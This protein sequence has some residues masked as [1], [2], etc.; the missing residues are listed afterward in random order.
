MKLKN[1]VNKA[2]FNTTHTLLN[3]PHLQSKTSKD[4]ILF[5]F[6]FIYDKRLDISTLVEKN[7]H[8]ILLVR[9]ITTLELTG[10][11]YQIIEKVVTSTLIPP[12]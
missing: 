8:L 10:G 6:Y 3:N 11:P 4:F 1:K 5:L 12:Y 7:F 9:L 2:Q